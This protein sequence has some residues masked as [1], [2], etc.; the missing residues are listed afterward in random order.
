MIKRTA[1]FL[2]SEDGITSIEYA[3]IALIMV[4]VITTALPA[5]GVRLKSVYAALANAF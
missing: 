5:V 3:L 2:I 4:I 1:H